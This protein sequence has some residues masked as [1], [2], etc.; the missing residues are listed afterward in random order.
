MSLQLFAQTLMTFRADVSDL[1]RGLREAA[2]LQHFVAKS[3]L[4]MGEAQNRSLERWAKGLT[5]V[6]IAF[7]VATRGV[8]LADDAVKEWEKAT[9][10]S[11]DGWRK[12]QETWSGALDKVK[13]GIGAIVEALSPLIDALG[14]VVSLVADIAGTAGEATGEFIRGA[15]DLFGG[16]VPNYQELIKEQERKRLMGAAWQGGF[17]AVSYTIER[18]KQFI[19]HDEGVSDEDRDARIA[20]WVKAG[21]PVSAFPVEYVGSKTREAAAE[22]KRTHPRTTD[23]GF[24]LE[25]VHIDEDGLQRTGLDFDE[26]IPFDADA[27]YQNALDRHRRIVEGRRESLLSEMHDVVPSAER[28]AEVMEEIESLRAKHEQGLLESM[29]GPVDDFNAYAE[30]FKILQGAAQSAFDTWVSGSLSATQAIKA[31]FTQSISGIASSMFARAIEHGA[32]AIGQLAFGNVAAAATHGKAAAMNAAGAVAVGALARALGGGG[33]GGGAGV[34]G[35]GGGGAPYVA[36]GGGYGGGGSNAPINV[37]VGDYF[38]E[39]NQRRRHGKVARA[40]RGARRQ[41]DAS[42]GVRFA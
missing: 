39:D 34:S 30:G 21:V 15:G 41:I 4:E 11:A 3:A 17:G 36:G 6:N 26:E 25:N 22:W 20:G 28:V 8:K 9:G 38:A 1:K 5:K 19:G 2:G 18:G 27:A 37:F 35:G 24:T 12:A 7:E 13:V 16:S 14:K 40:V 42:T 31:F 10:R 29:F 33:G 32:M 23:E